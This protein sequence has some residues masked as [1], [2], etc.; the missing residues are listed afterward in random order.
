MAQAQAQLHFSSL[1]N[2]TTLLFSLPTIPKTV[3]LSSIRSARCPSSSLSIS[4]RRNS[5][6]VTAGTVTVDSETSYSDTKD[7][8]KL[9][10]HVKDLT[11]V[12]A[13]S[14]QKILNGVNLTVY[15]GEVCLTFL[16]FF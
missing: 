2:P 9:L 7:G 3:T 15:E 13:E 16:H 12:I 4:N 6:R 10:L 14:Q 11:A 8:K 1:H 5:L